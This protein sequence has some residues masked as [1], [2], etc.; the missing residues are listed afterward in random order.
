MKAQLMAMLIGLIVKLFTPE[1]LKSFLDTVLDFVEDKVLGTASTVDDK[2][3][4]PL[5]DV[6]RK[7]Y[8]IPDD[9]P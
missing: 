4:L 2:L 6:I 8:N 7:A 1:L 9:D 5:C 3:V